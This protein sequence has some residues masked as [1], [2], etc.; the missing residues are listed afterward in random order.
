M[1]CK[2]R[3]TMVS[4]C[5]HNIN[6]NNEVSKKNYTIYIATNPKI[7]AHTHMHTLMN[8][9]QTRSTPVLFLKL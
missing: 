6:G 9:Q 4:Y 7:H 8:Y 5:N 2:P 1:G 3:H